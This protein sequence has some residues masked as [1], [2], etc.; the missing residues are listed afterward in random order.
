MNNN[1]NLAQLIANIERARPTFDSDSQVDDILASAVSDLVDILY[2]RV[3][4]ESEEDKE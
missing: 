2:S 3:M 4:R 1:S